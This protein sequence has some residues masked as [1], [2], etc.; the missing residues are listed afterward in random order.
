MVSSFF[1]GHVGDCSGTEAAN[2][3]GVPAGIACKK[4][5]AGRGDVGSAKSHVLCDDDDDDDDDDALADVDFRWLD[6][7]LFPCGSLR[8][9]AVLPACTHLES[10]TMFAMFW[11]PAVPR[12]RFAALLVAL[13]H[14]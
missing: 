2:Q 14:V 13:T 7:F 10:E 8:P 4:R 9:P 5:E 12:R 6:L 11:Q 1:A 3:A